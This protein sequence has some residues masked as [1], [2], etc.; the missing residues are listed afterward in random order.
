MGAHLNC[1]LALLLLSAT[2]A[3]AHQP[4]GALRA[5]QV[6]QKFTG[7]SSIAQDEKDVRVLVPGAPI[8][9]ELEGRAHNFLLLPVPIATAHQR[10]G[11]FQAAQSAQPLAGSRTSAQGE[12]DVYELVSG[13]AVERELAGGQA[14]T[15]RIAL[16]AGQYLHVTIDQRGIDAV[17]VLRGPDGAQLME[18]DG[19]SGLLGAEELSWEAAVSGGYTL[20]VRARARQ[21]N[22]GRYE[23]KAEKTPEAT[24]K[25][26]ARLA[27][28]RLMMEGRRAQGEG[29]GEALERAIK[30]Y[31]EAVE[32]WREAKERKSEAQTLN[33]LGVVYANLSQYEKAR[34]Y[35]EQA[36]AISRE[37]KD[38]L[39]E[40]FA[41]NALGIVYRSLSQYEQAKDYYEQSL[42]IK[43]E[44]KDRLGEGATLNNLGLV[45]ENLSQYE[46]A[47]A[48]YEQALAISRE[49]KDRRSEGFALNNLG[50]VY[51]SLSQYEQAKDYYQQALVIMREIK[52]RLG[53]GTTLQ[54]LGVVYE[55]LSQYERARDYYEQ[56][57]A[58]RREIK[59]RQ[60]E[61]STLNNLGS[62]YRRL[63][64]HE[65][66][67]AYFE[68]ALAISR[69]IKD[70]YVEEATLQHLGVVYENLSQHE[71]AKDYYEQALAITREI[72]YRYGEGFALHNLGNVYLKLSQHEKARAY[73]E[74]ALAIR[75]E[76]KDS[77]EEAETLLRV[78]FLER[79]R[80]NLS[81]A[82]KL[83]ESALAIIEN[84][85][86]SYTNR[87]LRAAYFATAQNS[88]EFYI[89]LLMR[90]HEQDPSAGHDA[91]ALQASERARAR[92]LLETL[93]E[94]G[95]DIRQ[96]VDPQLVTRERSLQQ[97]LNDKAKQQVN[98]LGRQHTAEQAIALAREIEA[99]TGEYQQVQA[100]ITRS[101]PRY[102]A[103][104]QPVPLGLKEIQ[105][106]ILDQD[107]LLLE[108]SLAE[109]RSFL[110]AVTPT[111]ITSHVLPK[112]AEIE[113]DARRVYE[114][115]T[116]RNHH[117][118]GET[119]EQRAKRVNEAEAEYEKA[120]AALSQMLLGPVATQLG[121]KRLIIV[122]EGALQYLPFA[123]L[124]APGGDA[125]KGRHGETETR[126]RGDVMSEEASD[127]RVTVS[128]RPR[129][130][131]VPLIAKH[132]I[133]TL[134]S[135]SV[136]AVLRRELLGRTSAPKSVAVL[137]DPVF[138]SD[139]PRLADTREGG[140]AAVGSEVVGSPRREVAASQTDVERSAKESG[141]MGFKRLRFSRQE[142]EAITALAPG[143]KS[144]KATDFA[145]NRATATGS[146]LSRY[147]V[148]H[149]ATHGLLNSQHPELSGIVL[150]LV[151]ERGHPQDGFLRL[152]EIYN[153]KLGADLV[154]LS[155]CQTALG[156][157]IK[158]EG[159]VGLTR[160]FMYA[161]AP[162]V[163]AS[164]W[165][166]DDRAT[167]ELMKRFYQ[168]MFKEGLRPAD[169]LRAAQTSLRREKGWGAPYYWAGFTLQGEWK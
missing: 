125:A 150:S 63:S 155:A 41:L 22:A 43:R 124:P 53:E 66:A 7:S 51:R 87:D 10:R 9:R 14:H 122:S 103:L 100:R 21:A 69:E 113:T 107:S 149:F 97:Q 105:Q 72:K 164:L 32:K 70:R 120:A 79:D 143:E 160:G 37:I 112:Q 141:V 85:R 156:K 31:G 108:Y 142:A 42:A 110:W 161:G 93:A 36:L 56:A 62:V 144:L 23:L 151:D 130:S 26:R 165:N 74:Q 16:T 146:E 169:A 28:E 89:D 158:G 5:A 20:E 3:I 109:E 19:V 35:F 95:A 119:P 99:L 78:A 61:G 50:I 4:A 40:G 126:G 80:G 167:A 71:K 133:V 76:I 11:T 115:L 57:L 73:Y 127:R 55:N 58:I 24:A 152:H 135:A 163:V 148:L 49:I 94:A 88:Y 1:T 45:Y 157:E 90:L 47:H 136:L 168:G 132:E 140:K 29:R 104:T 82:R 68:Q 118:P 159:L 117:P 98:F 34:G 123:A 25:D 46:K 166:V 139:D 147:R 106:Q 96:G 2:V 154:V 121:T 60:G 114:L 52:N 17:V 18:M 101:S 102:A 77:G 39:G 59:D 33:R 86:A 27:A 138:R 111:S 145:A 44:I 91:I 15:Y 48:Y 92:M 30:R 162:R 128:P 64:Q 84:L 131:F 6:A 153:L 81:D 75:R 83:I 65:K 8:E 38:R 134:P 67:R 116:A 13:T 12:S 129:V 54:N 137:A